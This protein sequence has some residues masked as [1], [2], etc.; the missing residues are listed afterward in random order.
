AFPD[1]SMKQEEDS[2]HPMALLRSLIGQDGRLLRVGK[3]EQDE[4][5]KM[6][7][8]LEE[9]SKPSLT[10]KV[11]S[12]TKQEAPKDDLQLLIGDARPLVVG[13]RFPTRQDAAAAVRAEEEPKGYRYKMSQAYRHPVTGEIRKQ[14]VR[15]SSAYRPKPSRSLFIDPSDHRK[16]SSQKCECPAHANF[17][18]HD[19]EWVATLV[20]FKHNHPPPV[21][22]G[23]RVP[24]M[25]LPEHRQFI[26][27]HIKLPK[28]S[29]PQMRGLLD[30][31]FG[32][33]SLEPRQVRNMMNTARS[34]AR[35]AM[36]QLGGD[37]ASILAAIQE[38]AEQNPGWHHAFQWDEQLRVKSLF[39][40]TPEQQA[41][42]RQFSDVLI[43]DNTYNTNR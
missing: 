3:A 14:T 38:S 37:F 2:K 10:N 9:D 18:D 21:P 12:S 13:Q 26:Q 6:G 31:Q 4:E 33:G 24:K 27:E 15:C 23:G 5:S 29:A 11:K 16:A 40:S 36:V 39:W 42:A 1:E 19:G 34:E 17:T 8:K 30:M 7:V 20:N 25:P 43:N 28:I 32:K 41:L 35:D 22:T